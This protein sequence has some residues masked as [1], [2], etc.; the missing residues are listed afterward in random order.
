MVVSIIVCAAA[1]VYLRLHSCHS[2]SLLVSVNSL[3][4]AETNLLL[5]Y[6]IFFVE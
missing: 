2:F 4:R 6:C 3:V 5:M 1:R